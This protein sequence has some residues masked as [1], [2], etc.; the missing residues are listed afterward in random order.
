MF[1]DPFVVTY[2]L[3]VVLGGWEEE[4]EDQVRQ[5]GGETQNTLNQVRSSQVKSG[6]VRLAYIS[7]KLGKIQ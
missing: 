3:A 1:L 5:C 4:K 6:Q 2:A 7:D